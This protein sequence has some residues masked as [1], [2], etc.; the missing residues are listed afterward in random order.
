MKFAL[1]LGCKIS[2]S[3]REYE[4][5]ARAALKKLDIDISDI[6]DFKC[7]GYPLEQIDLKSYLVLSARNLALAEK[8]RMNILTL[9]QCCFGSLK[10]AAYLLK[11][12]KTL[13]N[14]INSI[15][16]REGLIYKGGYEIFNL[17]SV[18][19]NNINKLSKKIS[20]P[21]KNITIAAHY[22][23]HALRPSDIT[24]LDNPV[25]PSIFER[26]IGVT[27]AET[28]KWNMRLECCG[29][30]IMGTNDS[31]SDNLAEKKALN[32]KDAGA[33]YICVSCPW[34]YSRFTTLKDKIPVILYTQLLGFSMGLDK[35]LSCWEI[36]L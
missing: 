34:C 15:L 7:C 32:A 22:G 18:L 11:T 9:C 6:A 5:S 10:K 25:N 13:Y 29:A 4:I 12:D 3:I 27:G 24:R 26:L 20:K 23:C 16:I 21:Y 33:D 2:D 8:M 30:P 14:E 19:D 1:F 36:D 35:K 28:V 17:L 31:L